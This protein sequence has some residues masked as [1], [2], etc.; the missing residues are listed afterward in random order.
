VP[1]SQSARRTSLRGGGAQLAATLSH[2]RVGSRQLGAGG[3]LWLVWHEGAFAFEQTKRKLCSLP[4]RQCKS[5]RAERCGR[6]Q[7]PPARRAGVWEELIKTFSDA[8]RS[9]QTASVGAFSWPT[10]G[11]M[12]APNVVELADVL[13]AGG[14]A[15]PWR[16]PLWALIPK[17]ARSSAWLAGG[18]W[19]DAMCE[20]LG[21]VPGP[22]ALPRLIPAR[23]EIAEPAPLGVLA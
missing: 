11:R 20:N 9:F 16:Q 2:A 19:R 1:A 17:P 6:R 13:L 14:Y 10:P 3:K 8:C 5:L 7:M 4:A 22:P 12:A 21:T 23:R 15:V 18:R